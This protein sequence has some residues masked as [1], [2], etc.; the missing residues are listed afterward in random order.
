MTKKYNRKRL[1]EENSTDNSPSLKKVNFEKSNRQGGKKEIKQEI[2]EMSKST[3]KQERSDLIW[4]VEMKLA[5][6]CEMKNVERMKKG[7]PEVCNCPLPERLTDEQLYDI[8]SGRDVLVVN[9]EDFDQI[10]KEIE[11]PSEPNEKLKKLFKDKM[12]DN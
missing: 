6:D 2:E 5:M 4:E 8:L 3:S 7:L 11:T 9:N 1:L 12:T 10:T